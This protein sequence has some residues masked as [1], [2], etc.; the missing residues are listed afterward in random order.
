MSHVRKSFLGCL[1]LLVAVMLGIAP[2]LATQ[3]LAPTGTAF[4][5]SMAEMK[6]VVMSKIA[7]LD[8][9]TVESSPGKQLHK[10]RRALLLCA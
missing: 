4:H 1:I 7:V 9:Q 2:R 3:T 6:G 10:A 5:E 8:T